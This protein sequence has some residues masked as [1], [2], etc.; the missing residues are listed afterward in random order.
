M[1]LYSLTETYSEIYDHRKVE[2]LFDNL[3]F[4]D[5][6]KSEDIE[7]VVEELVWEFR[8]Y[9]N[10]LEEAFEMLSSASDDDVICESYEELIEDILYEATV[11]R[12][13][14]PITTSI[15]RSSTPSTGSSRITP[16]RGGTQIPSGETEIT[17]SNRLDKNEVSRRANR[18][19]RIR[20]ANK[21]V[22]SRIS[23]LSGPISS[24]KQS[25]SGSAGGLGR[26]AMN[27]G[28]KVVE[29]GKAMLKSLLRRGGK[30]IKKAGKS[31]ETSGI[32]ASQ[33]PK[34]NKSFKLGNTT[35]T[36]TTEPGGSKR[37]AIGKAIKRVGASIRRMSNKKTPSSTSAEPQGTPSSKTRDMGPEPAA[38]FRN[39][40][41]ATSFGRL[42]Q[43]SP[44][45]DERTGRA[46][47]PRPS[48]RLK[49]NVSG[50]RERV[51]SG[52]ISSSSASMMGTTGG[53]TTRVRPSG[54]T[55]S[56]SGGRDL[57]PRALPPKGAGTF[58]PSGNIRSASQRQFALSR[59]ATQG[60][61]ALNK[62]ELDLLLQYIS[63]DLIDAGYAYNIDEAYEIINDLDES[64]LTEI[65]YDYI[66]E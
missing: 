60:K 42:S 38:A 53:I 28:G 7:Q 64:T 44:D 49:P 54:G 27:L 58:T 11:T 48:T 31:I 35:F 9:G 47:R 26:A 8:D 39:P 18:I 56:S 21:S 52:P 16:G 62:E 5:Y 33:E 25:I 45:S 24:V 3:R 12:S 10:T 50:R 1:S 55:P 17:S 14:V 2:D 34:S 41:S 23:K 13:K 65:I 57:F 43:K 59:A 19:A 66:E 61:K 46:R 40:P 32:R 6:M 4:I 63:E 20:N 36:A 15:K 30:S 22:K 29:K 51:S 37:Q